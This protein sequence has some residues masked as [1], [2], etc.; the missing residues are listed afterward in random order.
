MCFHG[1]INRSHFFLFQIIGKGRVVRSSKLK[2]GR[3]IKKIT[4][5][6]VIF[7]ILILLGMNQVMYLK[8]GFCD[9][10]SLPIVLFQFLK[11]VQRQERAVEEI[12][13]VLKPLYNRKRISKEHY[14]EILRKCVPKVSQWK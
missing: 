7:T 10:K 14:K 8:S 4:I 5:W 9:H 12:K 2:V 13:M 11:K 3:R 1:K 6:T